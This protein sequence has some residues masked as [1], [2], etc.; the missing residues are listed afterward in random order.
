MRKIFILAISALA[1]LFSCTKEEASDAYVYPDGSNK[2]PETV[3]FKATIP[4][5]KTALGAKDGDNWPNYWSTGDAISVNG[6][7]SEALDASY[8]GLSSASFTVDGIY[9][10]YYA[11]YPAS[12]VSEYSGGSATITIPD[13]QEYVD[14]SY[15]PTAY[16]MLASGS[17]STLSFTPQVAIFKI[18][19]TG[20]KAIKRISL[21]SKGDDKIAGKFTT[22]FAGLTPGQ[23]AVSTV[24]VTAASPVAA[25][26]PWFIVVP[27]VDF[28]VNGL[29]LSVTD[30]DNGVMTRQ[31]TPSKAWDAGKMYSATIAYTPD[32]LRLSNVSG[33]SSSSTLVFEWGVGD[34]EAD[35]LSEYTAALYSDSGCTSQVVSYTIPGDSSCWDELSALRF[36][37]GGLDPSTTYYCKVADNTRS[38]ESSVVSGTTSA[39]TVVNAPDVVDAA[40]GDVLLAEDFSEISWSPDE[41][42]YAAGFVPSPKEL[43]VLNGATSDGFAKYKDTGNRLFGTGVDL[44]SSRMSAGWGF[45][46]NSTAYI[47]NGY[48]RVTTTAESSRTHIV[49][50]ALSGIPAGKKA[51]IDVT[52]TVAKNEANDNDIAV[53]VENGLALADGSA[54]TSSASYKKYTGASLTGGHPFGVTSNRVWETK[55]VRISNVEADDQLLIGS[56]EN[57]PTKNRFSFSDIVV[58]LVELYTD[59]KMEASL[60]SSSSSTLVYEWTNGISEDDDIMH[61]YTIGLYTDMACSS[62]VESF[63]IE[64]GD[65][66]GTPVA[67]SC[68]NGTT[69]RFVF[70]GLSPATTYYF[71]VVNGDDSNESDPVAGT[72]DA[73][74]VVD[75]TAVSNATVGDVILAEDF[76][77]IGW[78]VEDYVSAAGFIPSI[79]TLY[80]PSGAYTSADGSMTNSG[81]ARRVYGDS[82]VES[83]KR[84]YHWGF[85]GNSAVYA[86]AAS[87]RVCT[88]SSGARTHIVTPVLAGIPDGKVATIDVTVT[89][90]QYANSTNDVGVFVE[91]D[92]DMTLVLEPDQKEDANFS[93]KGGKYEGASL[94]KG[95][96]LGATTK[97]WNTKTVRIKGV[98]NGDRL[99][100]GSY[101]NKDTKN[102]FYLSDVKVTIVDLKTPGDVDAVMNI[103]DF[104]SFKAFL[105]AAS[106]TERSIQGNVTADIAITP[107]QDAEID[108]LYPVSWFSGTINGGNHTISGLSKPLFVEI[109]HGSVSN[110]TLNSTLTITDALNNIGI[111][112]STAS[113]STITGCTTSGS[114]SMECASEVDGSISIGGMIGLND[115]STLDNCVNTA[116]VSNASDTNVGIFIG[117][118]VGQS[119]TATYVAC[120]N[121]GAVSNS[122]FAY[123]SLI[124][125]DVCIGGLIGYLNGVN[126]LTGTALAYNSNSGTVTE[127]STTKYVAMGG[128]AG[129]NYGDGSNLSYAKNLEDGDIYFI[130]NERAKSYIGGIVGGFKQLANLDYTSNAGDLNFESITVS[131]QI[132]IGGILGGMNS[133]QDPDWYLRN[134]VNSGAIVCENSGGNGGNMAAASKS[135]TSYSYVGGITGNGDNYNKYVYDCTNT[136]NITFYCQLKTRLGGIMGYSNKNPKGSVCNVSDK[137]LFY[138]YNPLSNGGNSEV[139]GV[140]GYCNIAE[141][142]DLTFIGGLQTTG[143]SP[144][145]FTAGI[146][147][148]TNQAGTFKNCH[149]GKSGKN[150]VGASSGKFAKDNNT[151][152]GLFA[153]AGGNYAFDFEGSIVATG[154][155]CQ[156]TTITAENIEDAVIGRKVPTTITNPPTIGSW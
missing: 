60:I 6:V 9:P 91:K 46:G 42:S 155:K 4:V 87:L 122:G 28:R 51:T 114:V 100:I 93:G 5:T 65:D 25:G 61:P 73:F 62:L 101:E 55:T 123:D 75:A 44:G 129:V 33:S 127:T 89:A 143:S 57:I 36:V 84:L 16:I 108:A 74:T 68:W 79:K 130:G 153:S 47:R 83:T 116:S 24:T 152:G 12:A 26:T 72:T 10:N 148:R 92:S 111:L 31:T 125:G 70:S 30:E 82:N 32:G 156:G 69:P 104:A 64:L 117:G 76:S 41:F 52:V 137:I 35:K 7:S 18:T 105:T 132:F 90:G 43:S 71:K 19:P 121:S 67:P 99:L 8:N 131:N 134:A 40:P 119:V 86:Q 29:E 102:R 22:D 98:T 1:V 139:G 80:V 88:S 126:T 97:E 94:S 96:A 48:L 20:S 141:F 14:G 151:T 113:G 85:F 133:L 15:D 39:F 109:N 13:E 63:T 128:I 66:N 23:K 112:A 3:T 154:T 149:V 53:F 54:G 81:T 110:L 17:T 115:G 49:T 77:E 37:F 147:G 145:A 107:A 59:A 45:F 58:E 106:N 150:I 11:A 50:P 103:S 2:V 136:G 27:A 38:L 142:E 21:S 34:V 146:I 124:I 95:Y 120:S 118:L 144:N 78:G 140:V 135:V 138:R 56:Y